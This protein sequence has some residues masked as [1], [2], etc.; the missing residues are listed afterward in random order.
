[1]R[2][3]AEFENHP[4]RFVVARAAGL[5]RGVVKWCQDGDT[6]GVF[7]DLGYYQYAVIEL[8]L[9][10]D[11]PEPEIDTPE[12][13]GAEHAWG[14]QARS[15]TESMALLCSVVIRPDL[16]RTD[17]EKKTFERFVGPCWVVHSDGSRDDL[18]GLIRAAGFDKLHPRS[19]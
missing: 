6:V 5:T 19:A 15:F 4:V 10:V 11:D 9:R 16:T 17:R 2:K 3:P 7:V 1:M 12:I 13:V 18:G 8:R 14:M